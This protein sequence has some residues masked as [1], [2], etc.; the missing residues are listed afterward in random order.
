MYSIND[1]KLE[2]ES[3]VNQ[4]KANVN[5]SVYDIMYVTNG[6]IFKCYQELLRDSRQTQTSGSICDRVGE[7]LQVM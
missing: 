3:T 2:L 1:G 5:I 6:C 7:S 4:I